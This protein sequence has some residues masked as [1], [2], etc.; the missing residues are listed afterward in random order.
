M[1][2]EYDMQGGLFGLI[3][4]FSI[5]THYFILRFDRLHF[6]LAHLNDSFEKN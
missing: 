4:V 5:S 6:L 2:I 1:D 3:L